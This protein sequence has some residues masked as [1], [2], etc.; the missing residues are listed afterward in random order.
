[1]MAFTILK[2]FNSRPLFLINNILYNNNQVAGNPYSIYFTTNTDL[3]NK[4][5]QIKFNMPAIKNVLIVSGSPYGYFFHKILIKLLFFN[6]YEYTPFP[7]LPVMRDRFHHKFM[8]FINRWL[9][10]YRILIDE[11]QIEFSSVK[12]NII[13]R[14]IC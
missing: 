12:R 8:P 9:I 6:L 2:H 5:I 7:E 1:M 13:L 11:W 14:N 3:T 4:L 10:D